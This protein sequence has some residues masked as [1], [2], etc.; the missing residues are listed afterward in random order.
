MFG[1]NDGMETA[2]TS[3]RSLNTYGLATKMMVV[4]KVPALVIFTAIGSLLLS[5]RE[6]ILREVGRK[7]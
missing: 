4:N 7:N 3:K 6:V 2:H 1:N 5:W